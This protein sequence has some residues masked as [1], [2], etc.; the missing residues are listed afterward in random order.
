MSM[1]ETNAIICKRSQAFVRILLL[2]TL[3]TLVACDPGMSI[4]ELKSEVDSENTTTTA[5][6]KISVDVK[7]THQLIGENWYSPRVV[8]TNSSNVAVTITNIE[9]VAGAATYE[10]TPRMARYPLNVPA[11]DSV[12]LDVYFHFSKGVDGV[13]KNPSELRIHYLSVRD[14]GVAR[15]T[16]AS[17]PLNAK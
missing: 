16:V 17:G 3:G 7:T 9:L 10:N 14:T 11:H 2:L 5:I 12:P 4:R 8:V 13:F 6:P 1:K 15:I